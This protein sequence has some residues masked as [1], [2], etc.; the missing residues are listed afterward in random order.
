M[1]WPISQLCPNPRRFAKLL[2]RIFPNPEP[3]WSPAKTLS[4]R[5]HFDSFFPDTGTKAH[6]TLLEVPF[7][8]AVQET[9]AQK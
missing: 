6:T 3:V 8:G 9:H 7:P 2:Q 5:L 1:P 4:N